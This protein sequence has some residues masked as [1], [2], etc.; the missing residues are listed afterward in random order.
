[1]K[2][3]VVKNVLVY[4]LDKTSTIRRIMTLGDEHNLKDDEKV[5]VSKDHFDAVV[6]SKE[7]ELESQ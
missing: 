4:V 5:F 3:T 2:I 7:R 6:V 1:M